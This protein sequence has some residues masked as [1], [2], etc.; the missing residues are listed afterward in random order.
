MRYS[1]Q[2]PEMGNNRPP[3]TAGPQEIRSYAQRG[4]CVECEPASSIAESEN[5]GE[6][7]H[8]RLGVEG[9]IGM[10]AKSTE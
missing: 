6:A 4:G 2:L 1:I 10:M 3:S 8:R 5:K 9:M 7:L